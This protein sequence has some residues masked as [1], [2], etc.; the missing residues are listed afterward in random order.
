[1]PHPEHYE[2]FDPGYRAHIVEAAVDTETD[3]HPELATL[4]GRLQREVVTELLEIPVKPDQD[5][6]LEGQ[7]Y[8]FDS[9][10]RELVLQ[11][12]PT[13]VA[14]EHGTVELAELYGWGEFAAN[15]V[16]GG[17]PNLADAGEAVGD[18][19]QKVLEKSAAHRAASLQEDHPA[20]GRPD[21]PAR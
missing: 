14:L 10:R 3:R 9:E 15:A 5:V 12:D 6:L 4:P 20:A 17:L 21:R 7:T 1:M 16:A 13:T 11:R 19:L 8:R 2:S 18:S